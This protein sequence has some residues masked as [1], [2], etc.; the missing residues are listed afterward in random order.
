MLELNYQF[1]PTKIELH[2]SNLKD[3]LKN[4]FMDSIRNK[5]KYINIK[6]QYDG[7]F[8]IY[9]SIPIFVSELSKI[10]INTYY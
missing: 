10:V 6:N 5:T 3:E 7:A 1:T 4:Q 2:C 9:T 8:E